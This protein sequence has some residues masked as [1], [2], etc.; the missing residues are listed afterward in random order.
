M[1]ENFWP[2]SASLG[3][4]RDDERVVLA[5]RLFVAMVEERNLNAQRY[6]EFVTGPVEPQEPWRLLDEVAALGRGVAQETK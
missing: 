3:E 5:Q 4:L 6:G 1:S 2:D